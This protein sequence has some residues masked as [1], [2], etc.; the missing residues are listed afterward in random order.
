M[1][2]ITFS[3]RARKSPFFNAT[4]AAG[5]T[6]F[7]IYNHTYFP[8]SYGSMEEDYWRLING[9]VVW[10]V[11]C[12]RQIQLQGPDATK[13]ARLLCTRDLRNCDV[14]RGMYAPMCDHAGRLLNDPLI[15][16]VEED[17]WWFSIADSDMLA[18]CRAIGAERALDVEIDELDVAP[19][20]VQGPLAAEVVAD[21]AGAWTRDLKFFRYVPAEIG[22][23][24]VMIG[25]AGYSTKGG[26]ELYLLDPTR[27]T[28][29]WDRVMEAGQHHGIAPGNPNHMER[30]E[31]AFIAI[32]T[33]TDDD[34]DPFEVRLGQYVSFEPGLDYIGRAALEAKHRAGLEREL[35][36]L[37]IDGERQVPNQEPRPVLQGDDQVGRVRSMVW[38]PRLETMISLAIVEVPNNQLGTKLAVDTSAGPRTAIVTELPFL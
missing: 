13:L 1:I 17:Q 3:P 19:L 14:G 26:F 24:P 22:G 28:E 10:D 23:I 16:R 29:L 4:M 33:D 21:L 9:V 15:L 12:Q 8:L 31:S 34:T 5:A 18:W 27:G 2:A 36:G 32:R 6:A 30:V 7:S 11:A 38:S 35:V 20:A 25:R 37:I